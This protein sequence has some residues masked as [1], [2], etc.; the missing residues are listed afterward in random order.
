MGSWSLVISSI[1]ALVQY[2]ST[3][4]FKGFLPFIANYV[5]ELDVSQIDMK[6]NIPR[7]VSSEAK[8]RIEPSA[9]PPLFNLI[10]NVRGMRIIMDH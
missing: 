7:G 1:L 10:V 9:P 5:D 2:S 4:S 8:A 3:S 6:N